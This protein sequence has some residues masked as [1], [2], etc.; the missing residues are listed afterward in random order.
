MPNA[1]GCGLARREPHGTWGLMGRWPLVELSGR[2]KSDLPI[3]SV[4]ETATWGHAAL[5]GLLTV[6]LGQGT[7][8]DAGPTLCQSPPASVLETVTRA[9]EPPFWRSREGCSAEGDRGT[10]GW[11]KP[12]GPDSVL[13]SRLHVQKAGLSFVLWVLPQSL[14]LHS[15][16]TEFTLLL[17]LLAATGPGT[18]QWLWGP[19]EPQSPCRDRTWLEGLLL[20]WCPETQ[21]GLWQNPANPEVEPRPPSGGRALCGCPEGGA[22]FLQERRYEATKVVPEHVGIGQS[23]LGPVGVGV[24]S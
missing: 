23:I 16:V 24:T 5:Y 9:H 12:P 7:S 18:L 20:F 21:E 13:T 19:Q 22:W 15:P 4:P 14:L 1:E 2:R 17:L 11:Q 6:I 8:L 3:P 10:F